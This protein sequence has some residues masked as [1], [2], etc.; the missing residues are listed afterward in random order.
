[1]AD[2]IAIHGAALAAAHVQSRVVVIVSVPL[3]PAAGAVV[4]ELS[5]VT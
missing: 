1:L 4:M 3:P 2:V 5:T